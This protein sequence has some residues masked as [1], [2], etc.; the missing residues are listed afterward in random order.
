MGGSIGLKSQEVIVSKQS[1]NKLVRLVFLGLLSAIVIIFQLLG[2]FINLGI[3]SVSLV[4]VPVVIGAVA[5]GYKEGAW[6]GFLSGCV[7]LFSG[8]AAAF[9]SLSPIGTAVIVLL[10]GTLSGLAAGLVYSGIEKLSGKF[11][12]ALTVVSRVLATYLAAIV[13]PVV[14]T[15]VYVI[16][17]L[18]VFKPFLTKFGF[19][20][21]NILMFVF[22]TMVGLN[23]PFE[24]VLNI[25][26]SP[27]ISAISKLGVTYFNKKE[28]K[29]DVY[30]KK[31]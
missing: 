29:S 28:K 9:F 7:I 14:N 17:C 1:H 15:G 27:V 20:G 19:E 24:L 4:L 6:L 23:F 21:G 13:C 22:I 26:L 3:T 8:A 18:T 10:K 25:I 11:P 31:A 5:L 30:R 16:G 2:N 12:I